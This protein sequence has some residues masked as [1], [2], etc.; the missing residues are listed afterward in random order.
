M[1]NLAPDRVA[2]HSLDFEF[3]SMRS[4]GRS[5]WLIPQ[6]NPGSHGK[7][8]YCEDTRLDLVSFAM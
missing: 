6:Q 5:R 3:E 8:D 2:G 7:T 1:E 4:D